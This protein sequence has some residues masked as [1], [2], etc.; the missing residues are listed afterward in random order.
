MKPNFFQPSFYALWYHFCIQQ[1]VSCAAVRQQ[2]WI[3]IEIPFQVR[4]GKYSTSKPLSTTVY[5]VFC[6]RKKERGNLKSNKRNSHIKPHT[7]V[8]MVARPWPITLIKMTEM[9]EFQKR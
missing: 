4:N 3:I 7:L 1:S 5:P 9:R 8:L 2:Y 6:R